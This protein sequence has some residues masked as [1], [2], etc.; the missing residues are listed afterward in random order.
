M[1]VMQIEEKLNK[2]AQLSDDELNEQLE[3]IKK[4]IAQIEKKGKAAKTEKTKL[5]HRNNWY[6]QRNLYNI[7]LVAKF[8]HTC[9]RCG[10]SGYV[11]HARDAYRCYHCNN[12][13]FNRNRIF[14]NR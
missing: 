9:K 10:G 6:A 4:E 14:W 8:R 11:E 5:K 12:P 2:F 3:L 1:H 13:D 7:V